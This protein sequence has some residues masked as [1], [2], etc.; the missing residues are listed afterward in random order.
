MA[1]SIQA[2]RDAIN[3]RLINSKHKPVLYL[4][5][6]INLPNS[7]AVVTATINKSK[8]HIKSWT[9]DQSTQFNYTKK[10]LFDLS[11]ID[12]SFSTDL[13]ITTDRVLV[14][15]NNKIRHL[16]I[17]LTTRDIVSDVYTINDI[18]LVAKSSSYKWY[19][20][21]DVAT[22]PPPGDILEVIP[23][24]D[25]D[26]PLPYDELASSVDFNEMI[27]SMIRRSNPSVTSLVK[28][29]FTI[30][31]VE[32]NQDSFRDVDVN[33]TMLTDRIAYGSNTYS[34]S[35]YQIEQIGTV[36]VEGT[37]NTAL[38]LINS[39]FDQTGC[40]F[41]QDDIV[42]QTLS[43]MPVGRHALSIVAKDSSLRYK[44]QVNIIYQRL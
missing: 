24:A 3:S 21:L 15:I 29:D 43:L 18:T 31:E 10:D 33:L 32:V 17:E 9:T 40:Y 2:L 6:V 26:E 4:D 22:Y 13:P 27:T 42:D 14:I 34:Y 30:T 7:A 20:T 41:T 1:D 16:G 37:F 44:G 25:L 19:G 28:T 11:T 23:S 35:R 5:N 12:L 38:E 36:G 8:T 39:I